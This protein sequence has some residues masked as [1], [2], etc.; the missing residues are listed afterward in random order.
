MGPR[1]G[2]LAGWAIIAADV[3]VMPSLAYVAGQYSFQL[4]CLHF[5]D[6]PVLVVPAP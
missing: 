2:W 5:A 3:L 4:L 1:S 6:R